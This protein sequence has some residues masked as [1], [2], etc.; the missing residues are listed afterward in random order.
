MEEVAFWN[1]ETVRSRSELGAS[2]TSISMAQHAVALSSPS[3]SKQIQVFFTIFVP[4]MVEFVRI[5]CSAW[6]FELP[7]PP[8]EP[9]TNYEALKY[10]S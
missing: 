3:P 10:S 6:G 1:A 7:S 2:D 5:K 4:L 8:Q 9:T